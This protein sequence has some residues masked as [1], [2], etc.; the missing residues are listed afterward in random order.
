MAKKSNE[1]LFEEAETELYGEAIK[2]TEQEVF[3]DALG[4]SPDENDGDTSLEQMDDDDAPTGDEEPT[5]EEEGEEPDNSEEGEGD[6]EEGDPK[7]D[8]PAGQDDRGQDRGQDRR[9]IPPGRLREESDARRV[10]EAE[11]RELRA[12]LENLERN[13]RQPPQPQQPEKPDMFAD[14]EGWAASQ[15]AEIE[16]NFAARHVN[17]SL[18]DT[19]EEHGEKF[20]EAYAA[21]IRAG[22]SGDRQTVQQIWDS[23]NPGRALMRWHDRQQVIRDVGTDPQAY[24]TRVARELMEDPEVRRQ[25][26]ETLRDDAMNGGRAAP[27]TRVRLPASLNSASG[28]A[29][30]RSRD[31]GPTRGGGFSA[32]TERD[33]ADSVWEN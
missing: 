15:R 9:G 5:D 18:N 4:L 17:A 1:Q 19:R 13:Q 22:Q 16:A 20:D 14:P 32:S 11:T 25:M 23:P 21:L 7:G 12:R 27:R 3:D 26:V 6:D 8:R 2:Q 29:G 33:I 30:H 28:G 31:P 10:A 24:R